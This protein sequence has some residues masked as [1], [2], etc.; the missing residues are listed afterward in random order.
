MKTYIY[1]LTD[2]NRSCLHVGYTEDLVKT[3]DSYQEKRALFFDFGS[4]ATRLVYFEEFSSDEFALARFSQ[5][6]GFTRPQKECLIRSLN[7]NWTD[8]ANNLKPAFSY[9]PGAK[10]K[11]NVPNV[12]SFR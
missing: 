11:P 12:T 10:F 3:I 4:F 5:L 2:C 1:I 7:P 8:L 9:H 6:S